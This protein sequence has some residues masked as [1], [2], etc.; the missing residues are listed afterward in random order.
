MT[1]VTTD[2]RDGLS[3]ASAFKGP[4]RVATTANI[5]LAGEQTIDGIACVTGDRVLVKDQTDTRFNGIYIVDTGDWSRAKDFSRND[6]V[7][8][9][10]RVA[11]TDGA[12]NAGG[13]YQVSA[14]SVNLD[15]SAM[16]FIF[17]ERLSVTDIT[18]LTAASAFTGSEIFPIV[19]LSGNRKGTISQIWTYVKGL[20][21]GSSLA[22]SGVSTLIGVDGSGGLVRATADVWVTDFLGGTS[23]ATASG[24]DAFN[25]ATAINNAINFVNALGGGTVRFPSGFDA[26]CSTAIIM[27]NG[28]NLRGPHATLTSD[29]NNLRSAVIRPSADMTSLITQANIA[30]VL[31]SAGIENLCIDGRKATYTVDNLI[32]LS[33]IYLRLIGNE[34]ANG[35]GIGV[36]LVNNATAA[37]INWINLNSINANDEWGIYTEITD[38]EFIGN[39][40]THNGDKAGSTGGNIWS[41]SFGGVRW[42]GNQIEQ[43]HQ[44]AIFESVDT[45]AVAVDGQFISCNYFDLNHI[46][47]YFK[48]GALG[49]FVYGATT[50]T[51]N[52]FN[53]NTTVNIKSDGYHKFIAL[54]GNHFYQVGTQ[55]TTG[56]I[57]FGPPGGGVGVGWVLTGNVYSLPET[58]RFVNMPSDITILDGGN[59]GYAKFAHL[60]LGARLERPAVAS[61]AGSDTYRGLGNVG[62]AIGVNH[63]DEGTTSAAVLI[64]SANG[65]APYIAASRYDASNATPAPLD[66]KT[67]NTLRMRVGTTGDIGLGATALKVANS[68]GILF[69]QSYT[70]ATLPNAATNALGMIHVSNESGG[71]VMAFSDGTNWRRVTD[72]AIVS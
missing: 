33:P 44:G 22:T 63:I 35:S 38:S 28:V 43:S 68:S 7:V 1:S 30:N 59:E 42:I 71:A 40:L 41:K 37:W 61:F 25:C 69:L 50:V 3:S 26:R 12:T 51:G 4:C 15:T 49:T 19:Q 29:G 34:I 55:P 14:S 66:I 39:H 72:R 48:K 16:T 52:K 46:D 47:I 65:Q 17:V 64:G 20:I 32:H 9:G 53:N 6:D 27:K 62:A 45:G 58:T 21:T 56:H 8:R 36:K 13:T 57:E 31:H 24:N 18:N 70:V 23:V 60:V 11:V 67:D 10:T 54:T 5:T 2:R